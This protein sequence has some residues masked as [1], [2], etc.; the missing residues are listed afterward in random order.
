M[1][2]K[3]KLK[4]LNPFHNPDRLKSAKKLCQTIFGVGD[5]PDAKKYL[6]SPDLDQ[7]EVATALV[8]I[9]TEVAWIK[10]IL[11]FAL[12]GGGASQ[13]FG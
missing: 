8:R 1:G 5:K 10:R 7:V 9:E 4:K 13:I 11:W 2:I 6:K 3:D 12:I